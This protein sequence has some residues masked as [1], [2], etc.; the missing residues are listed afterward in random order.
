MLTAKECGDP[1]KRLK[2]PEISA[3]KQSKTFSGPFPFSHLITFS[4]SRAGGR[5]NNKVMKVRW[6]FAEM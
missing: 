4:A 2:N 5:E 3:F 6:K 1:K